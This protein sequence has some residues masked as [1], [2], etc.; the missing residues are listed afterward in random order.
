[1]QGAKGNGHNGADKADD[2]EHH[3]KVW[4]GQLHQEGLSVHVEK[5]TTTTA[6][7]MKE[8]RTGGC[9]SLLHTQYI[10][11]I[12]IHFPVFHNAPHIQHACM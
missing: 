5:S 12:I 3:A 4:G 2:V 10:T 8:A 11:M 1:M 9:T 6:R 7:R